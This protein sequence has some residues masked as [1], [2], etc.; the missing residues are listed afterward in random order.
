MSIDR[1]ITALVLLAEGND[2]KLR[3]NRHCWVRSWISARK[4]QGYFDQ[5]L[6]ELQVTDT[7]AYQEFM[8]M[9]FQLLVNELSERL[10]KQDTTMRESIK[11]EEMCCLTIRYLATGESFRSLEYQFRISRHT[12]SRIVTDVC[13]ALFEIM[14]PK[15]L[16]VPSG[17]EAWNKISE[18]FNLR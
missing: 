8:R 11:P 4:E 16:A 14:G 1:N 3:K 17:Y 18:N 10:H 15:Y 5:L 6:P 7:K 12:I 13:R 9:D 2:T